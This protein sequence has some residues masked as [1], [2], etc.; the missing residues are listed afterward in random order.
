MVSWDELFMN[1]ARQ[2]ARKSKDPRTQVGATIMRDRHVLSLGF[3]GIPAGVQDL[4]ERMLP[5]TKY[6]WMLH[7]ELNAAA[8]A[9]CD[10]T[11]A[12]L[13]CTIPCCTPCTLLMIQFGIGEIVVDAA[14]LEYMKQR[15]W[16]TGD[17]Y[18]PDKRKMALDA[19]GEAGVALR[20]LHI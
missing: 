20:T 11:G 9:R 3:N 14:G 2:M 1:L 13:Y 10:L 17:W 12:T 6:N 18:H 5:P 8:N 19:L 16:G 15:H 7:A 4:P